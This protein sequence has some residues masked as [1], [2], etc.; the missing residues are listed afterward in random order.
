VNKENID[1]LAMSIVDKQRADKFDFSHVYGS[2][3]KLIFTRKK[4]KDKKI[5]TLN[6]LEGKSIA[7]LRNNLL[8]LKIAKKLKNVKIVIFDTYIE[9]IKA[10]SLGEID[11]LISEAAILHVANEMGM[12]Y[13][14][15]TI[16]LENKLDMVFSISKNI[17]EATSIINKSLEA[18]GKVKLRDIQYKWFLDNP[19][20]V[21]TKQSLNLA[22]LKYLK[23][24]KVINAC[25][26]PN[27]M[28]FEAF[29][30][31]G[32]HVGLSSDYFNK[33][34]KELSIPINIIKT[35]TWNETIEFSKSRKC[36]IIS[37]AMQTDER[38]KYLN[39][40]I[41]YLTTP[42]VLATKPDKEHFGYIG[43]LNSIGYLFQ[44]EF[45]GELKIAGKFDEKWKLG[46]A[47]RNDDEVLLDIFNKLISNV[48]EKEN[49]RIFNKWIAL[50]YDEKVDYSLMLKIILF[51]VIVIGTFIYWNRKLVTARNK[52]ELANKENEKYLEM[53]NSHVLIS[54]TNIDGII[55]DASDA[56]CTLTGYKKSEI[57]GKNHN[58][59]KHK[60]MD[61]AVFNNIWK[62]IKS[63]KIWKG[64]IKSLKKE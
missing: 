48:E 43:T 4:E 10:V 28:P 21:K 41:P 8:E 22:E 53:I 18:I 9:S 20:K 38:K 42:L 27:W 37:L 6:D 26:D 64:E 50:K 17:P 63:K 25:I 44:R 5:L 36:D 56:L 3:Q 7:V 23:N 51:S 62:T 13:L 35:K 31:N 59:F 15:P 30:K 14:E 2:I 33:F 19:N 46:I 57:I 12:P 52:L 29:D 40:S 61:D 16:F 47:V 11:A 39:F 54:S 32:I 1:G 58:V 60:D 55:T 45:A 34:S 49:T 24:K